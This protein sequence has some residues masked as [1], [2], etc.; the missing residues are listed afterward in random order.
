MTDGPSVDVMARLRRQ[1]SLL[2]EG[3][4]E[5]RQFDERWL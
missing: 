2:L 4:R 1:R 5:L 3:Y